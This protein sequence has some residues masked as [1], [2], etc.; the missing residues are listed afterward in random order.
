MRLFAEVSLLV[1][2]H[3]TLL[4][5]SKEIHSTT[6]HRLYNEIEKD[7]TKHISLCY[8]YNFIKTSVEVKW[9]L[10]QIC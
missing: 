2:S 9:R 5:S 1:K 7:R 10:C 4:V 6:L 3:G 8:S